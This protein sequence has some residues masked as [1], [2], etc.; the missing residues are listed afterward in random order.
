LI[1]GLLQHHALFSSCL[2]LFDL[3]T[4]IHSMIKSELSQ[5]LSPVTSVRSI[6]NPNQSSIATAV[7]RLHPLSSFQPLTPHHHFCRVCRCNKVVIDL[8]MTLCYDVTEVSVMIATIEFRNFIHNTYPSLPFE[9]RIK[10]MW[11]QALMSN[12][13]CSIG[14]EL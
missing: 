13:L 2:S 8:V 1:L 11:F 4:I 9:V 12:G 6:A 14:D 7:S 5:I 3:Q 10:F